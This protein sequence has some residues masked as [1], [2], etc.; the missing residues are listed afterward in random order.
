M[1][2]ASDTDIDLFAERQAVTS[3]PV[4]VREVL[5][6]IGAQPGLWRASSNFGVDVVTGESK[7]SAVSA[8][9]ALDNNFK[10]A[11]GMLVMSSHQGYAYYVIDGADLGV[12]DPPVWDVV[13]DVNAG[14]GW[15]S[16]SNWFAATAPDAE[17][18]RD[19]MESMAEMGDQPIWADDIEPR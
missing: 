11:A 9:S 1:T 13:E 5:R 16:V 19:R 6:L 18:L 7:S 2:G 10:D 15:M 3:V 14:N 4:A 17:D 8:L 12:D